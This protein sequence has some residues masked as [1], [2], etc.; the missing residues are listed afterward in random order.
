M[1]SRSR[2]SRQSQG[3]PTQAQEPRSRKIYISKE[4]FFVCPVLNIVAKGTRYSANR[5]KA[6]SK[7]PIINAAA[8]N[9]SLQVLHEQVLAERIK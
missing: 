2:L 4:C 3:Q 7:F 8:R 9:L 1:N 5:E 6:I